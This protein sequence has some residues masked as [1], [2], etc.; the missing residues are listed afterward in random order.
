[1]IANDTCINQR[2]NDA[3]TIGYSTAFNNNQTQTVK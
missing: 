3:D 1:M 2:P